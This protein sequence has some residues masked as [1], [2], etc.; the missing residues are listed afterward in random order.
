MPRHPG[1]LSVFYACPQ[2]SITIFP[3]L[4]LALWDVDQ[5]STP[6]SFSPRDRARK[7]QFFG[8]LKRATRSPTRSAKPPFAV[9]NRRAALSQLWLPNSRQLRVLDARATLELVG[10]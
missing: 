5:R 7:P 1:S 10:I 3:N 8:N 4:D 2:H 9:L 6:L